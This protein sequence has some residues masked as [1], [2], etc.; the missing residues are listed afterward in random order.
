[1]N[2]RCCRFCLLFLFGLMCAAALDAG[3]YHITG[4]VKP[5]D[6]EEV[7]TLLREA[8]TAFL[9]TFRLDA[10]FRLK[11]HVCRDLG[12]FLRL[13]RASSWNGGHFSRGT[14]YLQRLPILRER[15]ILKRTLA[16]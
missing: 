11:V 10:N 14:V 8:E 6:R 7:E 5:A 1:M 3:E 4:A 12:E 9:S 2:L 16:A 15:G 13:T